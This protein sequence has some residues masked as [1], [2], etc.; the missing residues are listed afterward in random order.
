MNVPQIIYRVYFAEMDSEFNNSISGD[1]SDD[2]TSLAE[3]KKEYKSWVKMLDE[4]KDSHGYLV[5]N[6]YRNVGDDEYPEYGFFDEVKGVYT[7]WRKGKKQ[8]KK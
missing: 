7:E 8:T 3:A 1:E 5:I 4:R 2:F 6:K